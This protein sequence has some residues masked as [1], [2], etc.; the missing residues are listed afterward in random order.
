MR[1]L[2]ILCLLSLAACDASFEGR[3]AVP[4]EVAAV[5]GILSADA[6]EQLVRLEPVRTEPLRPLVPVR[7][8]AVLDDET[9]GARTPATFRRATLQDGTQADVAVFGLAAASGHTYRLTVQDSLGR[10]G[11]ARTVVPPARPL[12]VEAPRRDSLRV[13][14]GV[15]VDG[16]GQAPASVTLLYHV[17][18][19]RVAGG[20]AGDSARVT[21]Q[22]PIGEPASG[23]W[24]VDADPQ[25]DALELLGVLGV[26]VTR[27]RLTRVTVVVGERSAEWAYVPDRAGPHLTHLLGA[28]ASLGSSRRSFVPAE[29]V[30]RAA[31]FRP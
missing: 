19:T 24:R 29:E 30:V 9:T 11:Q 20:V 25:R 26:T 10:T 28:F 27:V 4:D 13:R 31:G 1:L 5:Y 2:P 3:G 15:I 22:A 8:T 14:Q 6:P 18:I 23:G 7:L 12:V 16:L 17:V 21:V